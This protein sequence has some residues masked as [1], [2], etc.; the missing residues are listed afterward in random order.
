MKIL[1]TIKYKGVNWHIIDDV[2][3]DDHFCYGD[4]Y[5]P[6]TAAYVPFCNRASSHCSDCPLEVCSIEEAFRSKETS[7]HLKSNFPRFTKEHPELFI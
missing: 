4:C 3:S 2:K 1:D 5:I 7:V 6:L